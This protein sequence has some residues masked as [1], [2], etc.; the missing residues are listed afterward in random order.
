M[1]SKLTDE[2][3]SL[4]V[5]IAHADERAAALSGPC[6]VQHAQLASWLR[7]L[8]ERRGGGFGGG[9]VAYLCRQNAVTRELYGTCDDWE[10]NSKQVESDLPVV[11]IPES[12][13][14]EF[15]P[16]YAA[17]QF[18]GLH[19]ATPDALA[20]AISAVRCYD[21][22][23]TELIAEEMFKNGGVSC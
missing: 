18:A 9:P 17:P 16:L 13:D 21:E 22:M 6:A 3:L 10:V 14:Y 23:S 20:A 15:V 12:D 2:P 4:D 7:E 5:A 11:E 1:N 19:F 8:H